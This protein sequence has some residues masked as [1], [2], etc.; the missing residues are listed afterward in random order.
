MGGIFGSMLFRGGAGFPVAYRGLLGT[1]AIAVVLFGLLQVMGNQFGLDRDGFRAFVL[2]AASRRDILLGKNLTFAPVALGLAVVMVA[3][4]QF[5]AAMRWDHALAM[6]PQFVSMFLMFCL[7]AN[8]FSIYAPMGIAAGTLKPAHPKFTAILIQ[9][10]FFLV[11][12]PL[13]QGITLVPLGIEAVLG[14][15]GRAPAGVPIYLIL[16]ILEAIVIVV[17]YHF[18]LRWLGAQLHAREQKILET[19]TNRAA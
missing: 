9:L 16:A 13:G 17:L 8:L 6:A 10:A 4:V 3:G 7:L 19:V 2:S 1:G 12:F 14:A 5:L 15:L 11:V 18:S